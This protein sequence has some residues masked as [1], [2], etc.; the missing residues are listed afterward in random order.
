MSI[1]PLAWLAI[2]IATM[3][4][5]PGAVEGLAPGPAGP[6]AGPPL[7]F[8][9]QQDLNPPINPLKI[10]RGLEW[11]LGKLPPM[12]PVALYLFRLDHAEL[13]LNGPAVEIKGRVKD[14]QFTSQSENSLPLEIT[15]AFLTAQKLRDQTVFLVTNGHS[16]A[17]LQQMHLEGMSDW[18]HSSIRNPGNN[19]PSAIMKL[20]DFEPTKYQPLMDLRRYCQANK[21]RLTTFFVAETPVRTQRIEEPG[22]EGYFFRGDST[23]VARR[24][25]VKKLAQ[26][27]LG[28]TAT[29]W[30]AQESGGQIYYDFNS[31]RSL[32]ETML[33]K[34]QF[35]PAAVPPGPP[36]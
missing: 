14:M 8:M 28:F 2:F 23:S 12:Q 33:S 3:A 31:F 5:S 10:G 20:R 30:L 17:M 15:L 24:T 36:R 19:E 26:D 18:G 9:V 21:V 29:Q 6:A 25:D 4:F 16:Q 22:Q 11:L 7:I 32:F 35:N 13:V 27:S 34:G 1:R